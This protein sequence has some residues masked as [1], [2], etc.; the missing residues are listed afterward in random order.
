MEDLGLFYGHLVYFVAILVYV[1]YMLW[2]F[3]IFS[4]VL[5]RRKIWQPCRQGH[6]A[7]LQK[8]QVFFLLCKTSTNQLQFCDSVRRCYVDC[9]ICPVWFSLK[10]FTKPPAAVST[11]R[12]IENSFFSSWQLQPGSL[13]TV[14]VT[15][16]TRVST[17]TIFYD[18]LLYFLIISI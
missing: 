16:R 3:V 9:D 1:W 2:V 14:F 4:P 6:A 18:C 13:D 10:S 17:V 15:L 7:N 11:N 5:V 12:N 8:K